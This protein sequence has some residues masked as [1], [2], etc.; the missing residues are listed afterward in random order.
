MRHIY[1]IFALLASVVLA[2]SP[3]FAG[4]A[5]G[6]AFVSS[7]APTAS[8]VT[9]VPGQTYTMT[10]N[11]SANGSVSGLT[12]NQIALNP[13][14]GSQFQIVGGTCNTSSQYIAPTSCT[15]IVRFNGTAPGLF[16]SSLL[17]GCNAIVAQVGGY[18]ISCDLTGP[19]T[20]GLMARYAGTGIAAVVDA[21][22]REGLTLLAALLFAITGFVTL[23]RRA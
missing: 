2:G 7:S 11:I 17:M 19:G 22:G 4:V 10:A 15:V 13:N 1:K 12:F 14:L 6:T 18:T 3:A 21:L 5:G 20:A 8:P 23:R 16:T 9:L